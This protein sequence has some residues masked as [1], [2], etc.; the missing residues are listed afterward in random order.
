MPKTLYTFSGQDHRLDSEPSR[1]QLS[2]E[3]VADGPNSEIV[4]E[5]KNEKQSSCSP[6]SA[7]ADNRD[8]KTT[9]DHEDDKHGS[10]APEIER[11]ATKMRHQEPRANGSNKAHGGLT[12]TKGESVL[13]TEANLGHEVGG[14]ADHR[15]A[16][17]LLNNPGHDG[18]LSSSEI[19]AL[20]AVPIAGTCS[21]LNFEFVGVDHHGESVLRVVVWVVLLL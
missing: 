4:G 6:A 7:R 15:R 11:S 1:W 18:Q 17:C 2:D 16:R 8:T 20:E 10:L 12:N 13:L 21:L 5:C 9:N 14:P 19:D 3:R